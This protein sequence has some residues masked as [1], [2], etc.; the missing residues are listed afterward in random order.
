ML[1]SFQSVNAI[2]MVFLFIYFIS[3]WR[4]I[5]WIENKEKSDSIL[6]ISLKN[7][8]LLFYTSLW[9]RREHI[10]SKRLSLTFRSFLSW[11]PQT[12]SSEK[13]HT[14]KE[15]GKNQAK[16]SVSFLLVPKQRMIGNAVA[17]FKAIQIML[18]LKYHCI[19]K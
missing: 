8:Q 1:F 15:V 13:N 10:L 12:G 6:N 16:L 9:H 14:K 19:G 2:L 5:K 17:Y 11:C 3:L 18:I 7:K 4:K